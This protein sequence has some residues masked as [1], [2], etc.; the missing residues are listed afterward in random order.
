VGAALNTA[1]A[2]GAYTLSDRGTWLS[3][4]NKKGMRIVL[5]GDRR[6]LNFYDVILLN[7]ATHPQALQAPA[8]ML[9][10]WLASTEGQSAIAAYTK[11]GQKLFHPEAD[12]KP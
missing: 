4:A 7:P 5:E 2:M 10:Q 8:H 12:P 11:G 3:Y 6:L 9:A 1:S